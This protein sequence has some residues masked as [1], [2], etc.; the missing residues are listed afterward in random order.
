MAIS[1]LIVGVNFIL[2]VVVIKLV[3][4]LRLDTR[5][6]ETTYIMGFIFASQFIN[7]GFLLLLNE[8]NFADFDGGDGILSS[9]FFIGRYTDFSEQ[10]YRTTGM[11]L[12]RTMIVSAVFPLIEFAMFYSLN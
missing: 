3:Q 1:G 6:K 4:S 12:M 9:I 11:L 7:T 10:W 8:A 2:K 5:S